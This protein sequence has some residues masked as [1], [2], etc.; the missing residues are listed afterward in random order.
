MGWFNKSYDSGRD[1]YKSDTG[2]VSTGTDDRGRAAG[3]RYVNVD[4]SGGHYH[5]SYTHDGSGNNYKEYRGGEAS[6][7]RSYNKERTYESKW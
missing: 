7:D 2:R 5:E 6:S 1:S 3:H 4:K